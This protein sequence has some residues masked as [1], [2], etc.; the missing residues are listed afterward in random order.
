MVRKIGVVLSG[1]LLGLAALLLIRAL[2][3]S[4]SDPILW[5]EQDSGTLA[6]LFA[7]TWGNGQ[8]VVVGENGKIATSPDGV[9]WTNRFSGTS[10]HLRG[11]AWNGSLYVAAGGNS[12]ISSSDG[13]TWTLR[14]DA[15]DG[16]LKSLAWGGGL[17][18][19]VGSRYASTAGLTMISGDG[20]SWVSYNEPSSTP[21]AIDWAGSH[22]YRMH[23]DYIFRSSDGLAWDLVLNR[24]NSDFRGVYL[25]SSSFV[26]VGN[27]VTC[28]SPDGSG[29]TCTASSMGTQQDV[30]FSGEHFISG[31]ADV[32]FSSDGLSWTHSLTGSF[33]Y[34][35]AMTGGQ[36]VA[37]GYSGQIFLGFT[38]IIFYDGFESGRTNEWS[39]V[40]PPPTPTPVP[41]N[42]PTNTPTY[43]PTYTPTGPPPTPTPGPLDC[44]KI[45]FPWGGLSRPFSN[46]G[47][48]NLQ[49]R[50]GTGYDI[51]LQHTTIV[52]PATA[53]QSGSPYI[54]W[55]YYDGRCLDRYWNNDIFVPWGTISWPYSAGGGACAEVITESWEVGPE[56]WEAQLESGESWIGQTCVQ[57]DFLVPDADNQTCTVNKCVDVPLNTPTATPTW[58]SSPIPPTP[59]ITPTPTK[60]IV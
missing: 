14:S 18:I 1:I 54:D 36:V 12:I 60:E 50:N 30:V 21:L 29:W 42:T 31:G 43:T 4:S 28:L 35:L 49:L 10:D 33:I 37:V 17:F 52:S 9:T 24:S 22:F 45:T 48:L 55:L 38:D 19:A 56:N 15:D 23:E 2:A 57:L 26:A 11:V 39:A 53:A 7:V 13:V 58:T 20:I 8:Y 34:G 3:A 5:F 51:Y 25:G 41:I 40:V 27:G 44:T 46:S 16:E 59:T 32:Y 47:R 6:D